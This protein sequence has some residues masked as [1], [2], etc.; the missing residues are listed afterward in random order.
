LELS[1]IIGV[2]ANVIQKPLPQQGFEV[3]GLP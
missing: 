2:S 3:P 1:C